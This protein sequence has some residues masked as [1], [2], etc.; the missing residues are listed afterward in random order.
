MSMW[1]EKKKEHTGCDW[2]Y[3]NVFEQS[4]NDKVWNI[5]KLFTIH[6]N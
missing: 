5:Y 3:P 1:R 2:C 6:I 4:H